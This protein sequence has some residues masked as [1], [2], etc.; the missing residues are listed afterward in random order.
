MLQDPKKDGYYRS[1]SMEELINSHRYSLPSHQIQQPVDTDD[2][3]ANIRHTV[4][5]SIIVFTFL[6]ALSVIV[7]WVWLLWDRHKNPVLRYTIF[8]FIIWGV[9]SFSSIIFRWQSR[10]LMM[11]GYLE[12]YRK[13]SQAWKMNFGIC[14]SACAVGTA[15]FILSQDSL[16]WRTHYPKAPYIPHIDWNTGTDILML[17]WTL[18]LASLLLSYMS[19]LCAYIRHNTSRVLPDGLNDHYVAIGDSP[20]PRPS[21]RPAA[22]SNRT[23]QRSR[24]SRLGED[25]EAYFKPAIG[26]AS[27]GSFDENCLY[28]PKGAARGDWR[29]DDIS[30]RSKFSITSDYTNKRYGNEALTL[31]RQAITIRYQEKQ[32]KMLMT[33]LMAVQQ[34]TEPIS[35]SLDDGFLSNT[36]PS[37]SRQ[38]YQNICQEKQL[39]ANE[40]QSIQLKFDAKEAE[41]KALKRQMESMQGIRAKLE[42]ELT[43]KQLLL[44]E[45]DGKINELLILLE[46]ARES[47]DQAENFLN[48][49][50]NERGANRRFKKR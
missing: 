29:G 41:L 12:F 40:F 13:S 15:F 1:G 4:P 3:Y 6:I 46:V 47:R 27:L 48:D 49:F 25:S 22:A 36:C 39:L 26:L 37:V 35:R 17:F 11:T 43:H 45:K 18:T 9:T 28:P 19:L 20:E 34:A 2:P 38:E 10:Q 24:F 44:D 32:L 50:G 42:S 16:C 23:R 21:G 5:C 30:I 7:A 33:Q 31:H 14:S 8:P